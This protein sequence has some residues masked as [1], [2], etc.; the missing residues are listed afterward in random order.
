MA[1]ETW[2]LD[3]QCTTESETLIEVCIIYIYYIILHICTT[4]QSVSKMSAKHR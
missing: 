1:T 4:H 3:P 2:I